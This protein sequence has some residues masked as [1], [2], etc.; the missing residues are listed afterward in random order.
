MTMEYKV[1]DQVRLLNFKFFASDFESDPIGVIDEVHRNTYVI[2]MSDGTL[3]ACPKESTGGRIE[4]VNSKTEFE[5]CTTCGRGEKN[6]GACTKHKH[7]LLDIPWSKDSCPEC[8]SELEY[9][10]S[11]ARKF[12]LHEGSDG[13][14]TVHS[15]YP[16]NN[17]KPIRMIRGSGSSIYF[18]EYSIKEFKKKFKEIE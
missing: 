3:Q 7:H 14:E 10:K 17:E 4:L 11:L 16:Q 13:W 12:W 6:S 9:L 15:V 18:D 8:Q 1:G 5:Y 2:E